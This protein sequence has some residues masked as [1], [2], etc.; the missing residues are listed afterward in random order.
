MERLENLLAVD[1]L[2]ADEEYRGIENLGPMRQSPSGVALMQRALMRFPTDERAPAVAYDLGQT[3]IGLGRL[4]EAEQLLSEREAIDGGTYRA[5]FNGA[6]LQLARRD[7]TGAAEHFQRLAQDERW[8]AYERLE[9][10]FYMGYSLLEGSRFDEAIEVFERLAGLELLEHSEERVQLLAKG[11]QNQLQ[12]AQ[13]WS[14]G[15]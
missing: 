3:L 7:F 9:A 11:A 15:G 12:R 4:D 13:Q 5:A 14:L 6:S 8:S 2:D 1:M 10:E